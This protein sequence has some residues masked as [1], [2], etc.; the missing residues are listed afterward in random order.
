[1]T[2]KIKILKGDKVLVITGKDRG[3]TGVIERVMP[4]NNK[5]IVTGLNMVKN[6][7]KKSTKNP[8]GGI[9]DIVQPIHINNV[10]LLDP[11][12][13]KPTRVGYSVKGKDKHRVAKLSNEIIRG[14]K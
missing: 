12:Q 10:M 5:V 11:N 4:K 8:Q 1:M 13:N 14:E 3:K 7:L 6:H 2:K 9:I